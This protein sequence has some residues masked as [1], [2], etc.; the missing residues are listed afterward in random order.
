[1]TM[2]RVERQQHINVLRLPSALVAAQHSQLAGIEPLLERGV[3]L[4]GK[5]G[6]VREPEIHALARERMR[7]V[8][9]IA[10]EHSP[11][12]TIPQGMQ[13]LQWK[14]GPR[15]NRP[16]AP[17][18]AAARGLEGRDELVVAGSKLSLRL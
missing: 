15:R 16:Q 10:D 6:R 5:A 14:P 8:R 11:A 18:D 4:R 17:E 2:Q 7:H 1:E 12:A 13:D 9:R 3:D